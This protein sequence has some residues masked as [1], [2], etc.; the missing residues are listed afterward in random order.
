MMTAGLELF[1]WSVMVSKLPSWIAFNACSNGFLN[2][3]F[4]ALPLVKILNIPFVQTLST[5][6]IPDHQPLNGM[7]APFAMRIIFHEG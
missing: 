6:T 3:T 1:E 4:H 7:S 5:T 2:N